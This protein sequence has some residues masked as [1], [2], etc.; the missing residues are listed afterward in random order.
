M[1]SINIKQD[2]NRL[3]LLSIIRV[4]LTFLIVAYHVSIIYTTYDEELRGGYLKSYE[5]LNKN[6][7]NLTMPLFVAI[8]GFLYQMQLNKGKYSTIYHIIRTKAK[9]L[10]IPYFFWSTV[11]ACLTFNPMLILNGTTHLWFLIM[12]FWL[13]IICYPLRNLKMPILFILIIGTMFLRLYIKLN[14]FVFGINMIA[15]LLVYFIIGMFCF[16]WAKK[17][18]L[19]TI[20][21]TLWAILTFA[22]H[23][24]TVHMW[25]QNGEIFQ[26]CSYYCLHSILVALFIIPL[27]FLIHHNSFKIPYKGILRNLDESSIGIY[28]LHAIIISFLYKFT[29]IINLAKDYPYITPMVLTILVFTTTYIIS[30][31]M[32]RTLPKV[33]SIF[34]YILG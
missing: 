26:I 16:N 9:R 6:I 25:I 10:L 13:F 2:T 34:K 17:I 12:L 30:H 32:S 14:I 29:T 1:Q 11:I 15:Q 18:N 5:F 23:L 4:I 21:L 24:I 3:I 7:N 27:L 19:S 22:I 28:I 20:Q 8:S 33:K 31:Y